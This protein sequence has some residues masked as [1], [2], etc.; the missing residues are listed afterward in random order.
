[1]F[2][3]GSVDYNAVW[4]TVVI[5]QYAEGKNVQK[6]LLLMTTV[7]GYINAGSGFLYV[8][9]LLRSVLYKFRNAPVFQQKVL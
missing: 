8:F 2:F 6:M 9:E 7:N 3:C 4:C 5:Q 1:V